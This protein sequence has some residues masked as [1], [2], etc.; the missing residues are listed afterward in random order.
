[1]LDHKRGQAIVELLAGRCREH[2]VATLM[3]THDQSML[4][5]A[6]SVMH[7]ADGRLTQER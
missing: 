6:D 3:V 4:A 2:N 7:I 1:M 5:T